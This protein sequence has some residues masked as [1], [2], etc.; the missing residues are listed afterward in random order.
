MGASA[1]PARFRATLPDRSDSV[2]AFGMTRQIM[3]GVPGMVA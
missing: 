2:R 3:F 1:R